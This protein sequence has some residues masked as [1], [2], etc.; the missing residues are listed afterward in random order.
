MPP[1]ALAFGT[2]LNC[3]LFKPNG[4]SK[5]QCLRMYVMNSLQDFQQETIR[6]EE[7]SFSALSMGEGP[8][9]LCLHGFP[10]NAHSYRQQLP[11]L[12]NAGYRA[13]SLTLRGY[14]PSSQPALAD[15]SQQSIAGDVIACIEQLSA[16]KAHLIGHDWGA[17]IAYQAAAL[18]P[19]R[20][21]SL[22]TMAVP[23]SGRFVNEAIRYPKQLRLSWYMAFFQ[24]RGIAEY[25]VARNDYQFIRKLWRDWSPG[26]DIPE[27]ALHDVVQTF[28]Q[29]GVLKAALSYYRE[30]LA[31][32]A[33][34]P[35]ARAAARF[36]VAVPTLALTGEID[37]CID[38]EVFQA[39]MLAEDFPNGLKV[40]QIEGA[41]H[42]PHQEKPDTVNGLILDWIQHW[43]KTAGE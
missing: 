12:A 26:W 23:H 34:T 41:G 3:H 11:V 33:F 30:A 38:S 9:V 39:M 19:E 21:V 20:F 32:S 6:H 36:Q 7:L 5:T 15:Y 27:D 35:S 1:F 16:D 14:E 37:G 42:F 17:S 2:L 24:L 43:Q 8:L 40:Q 28:K 29:P 25:A 31:P 13:V 18:A 22:T 4:R 10:D